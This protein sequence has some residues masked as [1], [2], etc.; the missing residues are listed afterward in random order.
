[1]NSQW[2]KKLMESLYV[3]YPLEPE[4]DKSMEAFNLK[5][6]VLHSVAL[7]DGS[8]MEPWSF[9]GE[10]QAAIKD[11]NILCLE[12][13]SRSDHWP[14]SEVRA[15]D[16]ANGFYATFGSYIAHLD[17]KGLDLQRGNRIWFKIKPVCPGLHSPI[18]R[19]GFVNNGAIKIPDAYSREGFHAMNLKNNEWNIFIWEIDAIAHDAIEEISFNIHRY[20]KEVSSGDDLLFE[21]CDIQLQ[22]VKAN[23]VHGWQC[24]QESVSY[25]TTGYFT[26][27]QK[28]AIANTGEESFEI[29]TAGDQTVVYNGTIERVNNHFG[30]FDV[31]DFTSLK[32]EGQYRIRFG[33]TVSEAFPIGKEL[34]E[35]TLWKL[36]N[37]LYCERCGCP[38]PNCHGTCHQDVI[39]RHNGVEMVYSGGW[40]D[41]ADVSQQT[42][43]TAEIL[44]AVIAAAEK[45]KDTNQLLYRRMM[46]EA[47]WGLDFILRMRFGDGY[48]ASHAALRRWTDNL[49]GNMDDCE[50]DVH[51]RSFENFVF[52]A[53]QAGAAEAWKE[54]DPE[55]SWKCLDAA[56]EDF[57]FADE[58]FRVVGLEEPYFPEHTAGAGLS[59]YY[60]VAAWAAGKLYRIA[61]EAYYY[62]CAI[63]YAEKVVSCQEDGDDLPMKGFFYRDESKKYIIH[64]SH[65][66]RDHVF[67]MALAE[68]CSALTGHER[69]PV[70]EE[71]M[72]LHGEY[73]KGLSQYTAPYGMLPA[74]IHHISEADDEETFRL[75]HPKVDYPRERVNYIEQLKQGIDLGGGYYIKTFP[76]WFSYRGNSAIHLSMGK[77]ASILGAYFGDSG[78]TEI[79]REQLYWTLG[80][81]PFGQS[82]IYGAGNRYGQ[83]YTALLGET[84]GEMPVGVQ[85]RGNEDVPYWPQGKIAT[86]REVWTT[87]PGRWMWIAAD[88]IGSNL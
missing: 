43:Q 48:R 6:P 80:K 19:V 82:L 81:N 40:H 30:T 3:H 10:G 62:D 41:A 85:T 51:N 15:N 42:M 29:I 83:Q 4:C 2:N 67:V 72:K 63:E 58:R 31:L 7:W 68:V 28:I 45:V 26:D 49:I 73:L 9:E 36:I 24:E 27:G 39:A 77:A 79:A 69:V 47:N 18:I 25:A 34:L 76:V 22:E 20:G 70:W 8:S 86:Y 5:K 74:G 78:L 32:T 61:K 59:Q 64:F 53:V 16:A 11:G 13:K 46:E 55:L 38:V 50:A 66:A 54:L 52:A 65:Q 37:F 17:V 71:A 44:D 35:S 33:G 21:L 14:E 88:L 56:K 57:K 1:M 87:P 23:V 75:V 12:T 60:A 84:V